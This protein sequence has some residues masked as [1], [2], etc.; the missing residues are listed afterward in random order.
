ME[1]EHILNVLGAGRRIQDNGKNSGKLCGLDSIRVWL[2]SWSGTEY[3]WGERGL[4]SAQREQLLAFGQPP[5]YPSLRE[6]LMSIPQS[7]L[8]IVC[9]SW[10]KRL[11]LE[12]AV[13]NN[14]GDKPEETERGWEIHPQ[15]W[16][17]DH[18]SSERG[19]GLAGLEWANELS[20]VGPTG[21]FVY[22]TKVSLCSSAWPGTKESSAS[23]S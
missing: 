1:V 7:S 23:A 8:H 18:K 13:G 20:S 10:L 17:Q 15:Y 3:S 5:R 2:S 12:L 4:C 11:P 14:G 22:W 16:T 6:T 19:E 21:P 9:T